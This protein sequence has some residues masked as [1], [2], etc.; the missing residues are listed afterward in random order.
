MKLTHTPIL[1]SSELDCAVWRVL[2]TRKPHCKGTWLYLES[3]GKFACSECP[4]LVDRELPEHWPP[5]SSEPALLSQLFDHHLS[6]DIRVWWERRDPQEQHEGRITADGWKR[7]WFSETR[8]NRY[9]GFSLELVLC[10]GLI[11]AAGE[12]DRNGL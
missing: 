10:R 8:F 6:H 5:Y 11:G 2:H 1:P 4:A 3:V 9:Q 7:L 12:K